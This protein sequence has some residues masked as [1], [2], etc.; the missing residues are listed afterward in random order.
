MTYWMY[1]DSKGEWRWNLVA[2]NGN[3]IADSGEGYKN[4]ADCLAGIALVKSSQDAPVK[5]K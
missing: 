3:K 5:K 1:K 2:S 4:E